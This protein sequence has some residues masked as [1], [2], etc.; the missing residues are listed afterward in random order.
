MTNPKKRKNNLILF[1]FLILFVCHFPLNVNSIECK[2]YDIKCKSKKFIDN[3]I[4][5]QKEGIERGKTQ[6]DQTKD[7]V[8]EKLP[9]KK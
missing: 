5:F 6:I 1:F 9:K 2:K 4:K 8:I 7:K 3:T